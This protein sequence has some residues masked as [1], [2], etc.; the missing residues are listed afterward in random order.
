MRSTKPRWRSLPKAK[1]VHAALDP[2]ALQACSSAACESNPLLSKPHRENWKTVMVVRR[3][4]KEMRES[5][6]TS[7]PRSVL[8]TCC[9]L[10]PGWLEAACSG[11]KM[12]KLDRQLASASSPQTTS[13]PPPV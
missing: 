11:A 5:L 12:G 3:A 1:F 10:E 7:L 2:A 9:L 8:E 4:Q 6:G 13:T